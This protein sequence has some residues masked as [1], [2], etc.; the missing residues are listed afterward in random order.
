MA[1]LETPKPKL[2]RLYASNF[3]PTPSTSTSSLSP[4]RNSRCN[5]RSDC[6]TDSEDTE[7]PVRGLLPQKKNLMILNDDCLLKLFEFLS[8]NDI[9]NVAN[10]NVR[11]N[12]Q[13]K[14][15]I[16]LK[17]KRLFNVNQDES[18]L[19]LTTY[20]DADLN[21]VRLLLR[22]YGVEISSLKISKGEM[23]TSYTHAPNLLSMVQDHCDELK[24]LTLKGYGMCGLNKTFFQTLEKLTLDDCSVA[25]DW[26]EMKNLRTLELIQTIFRRWPTY[27]YSKFSYEF[28]PPKPISIPLI[29]FVGLVKLRLKDVNID[30]NHVQEMINKNLQLR[31]LAIVKC[32]GV[33]NSILAAVGRLKNLEELEYKK[34]GENGVYL[35]EDSLS[36]LKKL[37]ILKLTVN[38]YS[39]SK[40]FNR[41]VKNG[42][43]LEHLELGAVYFDGKIDC[44]TQFQA[45]KVLKF[46]TLIGLDQ[47]HIVDIV[48]QL[49]ELEKLCVKINK[50]MN[51]S[52]LVQIV[53]HSNRLDCLSVEAPKLKVNL[54]TCQTIREMV[55]KRGP[56]SR[57]EL[58][59]HG[60]GNSDDKWLIVNDKWLIVKILKAN[61][62]DELK[63][64]VTMMPPPNPQNRY[65]DSDD[66]EDYY[67]D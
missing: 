34:R 8:L 45:I 27:G 24:V 4:T 23:F 20:D 18:A 15:Y 49:N 52:S 42:I 54:E 26:C 67:S 19:D 35:S 59:I 12:D 44:I 3:Y 7:L 25:R 63:S 5:L 53:Q 13:A 1:E 38:A 31:S 55:Q 14:R 28:G 56:N 64:K 2:Q 10:V 60:N 66:S 62:F 58:T 9:G 29:Q 6:G 41:F 16:R 32:I 30:N 57:L 36:A 48:K 40:M 51:Q 47:S 21:A 17:F 22:I 33:S 50:P 61:L 39:T 65:F 37:K 46:N 11:L 43:A